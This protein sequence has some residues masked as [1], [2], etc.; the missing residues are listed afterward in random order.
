[1]HRTNKTNLGLKRAEFTLG[2]SVQNLQIIGQLSL[3]QIMPFYG[4]I[5]APKKA[6]SS[7]THCLS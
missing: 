7:E 2:H 6:N 1:M 5:P 3:V 4:D